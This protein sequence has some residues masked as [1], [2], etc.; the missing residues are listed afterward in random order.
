M[1]SKNTK[2]G[3]HYKKTKTRRVKNLHHES[4]IDVDNGEGYYGKILKFIGGDQVLWFLHDGREETA[5][6]PGRM[7]G[8]RT[9]LSVGNTVLINLDMEIEEL[10]RLTNN[11]T[12]EAISKFKSGI[13]ESDLF[14]ENE[15]QEDGDIDDELMGMYANYRTEK[16]KSTDDKLNKTLKFKEREKERDKTRKSGEGRQFTDPKILEAEDRT[17][18]ND[19][20]F[21]DI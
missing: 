7:L 4:K 20:S 16:V 10:I 17:A 21:D 9:K 6:I 18:G 3:K 5:T 8:F 14:G 11:R 13:K 2:G 1:S 19:V 12:D 15:V